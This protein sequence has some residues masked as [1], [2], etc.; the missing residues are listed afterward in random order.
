MEN[1]IKTKESR[2]GKIKILDKPKIY[3]AR[4]KDKV[5]GNKTI[6]KEENNEI[7][8]AENEVIRKAKGVTNIA[9]QSAINT[10]K[11]TLHKTIKPKTKSTKNK[12]KQTAMTV[13]K[14]EKIAVKIAKATVKSVKALIQALS[15]L[16]SWIISGGTI[17]VIIIIILAL[18]AGIFC[19]AFGMFFSNEVEQ[20]DE[21]I[22]ISQAMSDLENEVEDEIDEIID[23]VNHNSLRLRRTPI[24]WKDIL[25]IYSIVTTNRED[26]YEIIEMNE[27]N[28]KKLREIFWDVVSIDYETE[29]Y[30]VTVTSTDS[31]GN[32]VKKKKRRTR[33]IIYVEYLTLEEMIDM[34]NL[35][36]EEK[37]QMD[38]LQS[39]EYEEFWK[40]I[41]NEV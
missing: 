28:Y 5:F 7:N 4:V 29:R 30:T 21:T 37:K 11:K 10:T 22:T 34:Y 9:S 31:D 33:L 25:S 16:I 23:D 20:T 15:S 1:K 19:S 39:E 36:K 17:A 14:T 35:N 6:E 18:V 38:E 26:K 8:Y 12:I 41:L 24:P 27:K 13:K 40:M 32:T 3:T 2:K